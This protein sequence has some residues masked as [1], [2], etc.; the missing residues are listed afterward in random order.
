MIICLNVLY[1]MFMMNGLDRT[2]AHD[3]TSSLDATARLTL[4]KLNKNLMVYL[5]IH[6]IAWI[7]IFVL[8]Y[9]VINNYV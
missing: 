4:R 3:F 9:D 1:D 8:F 6:L 2:N 7:D 5:S